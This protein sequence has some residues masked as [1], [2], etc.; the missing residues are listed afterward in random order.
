M[1]RWRLMTCVGFAALLWAGCGDDQ[2][3]T[4]DAAVSTDGGSRFGTLDT[5]LDTNDPDMSEAD[6]GDAPTQ[7]ALAA[8]ATGK[9][10]EP[11]NCPGGAGCPCEQAINCDIA[12]CI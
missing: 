1:G 2:V 6:T 12:L 3:A 5:T 4:G 8:D 11:Q 7:D 10:T 9:D